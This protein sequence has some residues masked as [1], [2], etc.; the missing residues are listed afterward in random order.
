MIFTKIVVKKHRHILLA[1]QISVSFI[2]FMNQGKLEA[3]WIKRFKR[4]PMDKTNSVALIVGKG[5]V[6]NTDQGGKRQV[7]IIEK[8]VWQRHMEKLSASVDPSARRANLMV[9]GIPLTNSRGRVLQVGTCRL[10]IAGETKPC[11]R[12]DEACADLKSVMWENWGG[13]AYAEV[14]DD[15]KICV[16]DS[17]QWV[18]EIE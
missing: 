3:I 12:M 1:F 6:D 10:L 5:L 4:G 18:N 8:E 7:T 9:S 11:E 2:H 15:G 17:V 14:L 13:G 16:G